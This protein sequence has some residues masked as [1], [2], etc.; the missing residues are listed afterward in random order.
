MA[1]RS[2][3]TGWAGPLLPSYVEV[4]VVAAPG[5]DEVYAWAASLAALPTSTVSV[6]RCVSVACPYQYAVDE[7]RAGT[8]STAPCSMPNVIADEN[9][10]ASASIIR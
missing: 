10:T 2:S 5:S 8:S 9:G 6:T 1:R 3:L 4:S 7:Y